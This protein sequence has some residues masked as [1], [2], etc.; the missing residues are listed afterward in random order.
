M[1][2][3]AEIDQIVG[4]LS[5]REGTPFTLYAT[6]ASHQVVAA[7]AIFGA[8]SAMTRRAINPDEPFILAGNIE[9]SLFLVPGKPPLYLEGDDPE[10]SIENA[11]PVGICRDC[12]GTTPD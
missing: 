9:A 10:I 3:G 4:L 5:L 11:C 7:N 6:P 8:L 12:N 1:L 2:T